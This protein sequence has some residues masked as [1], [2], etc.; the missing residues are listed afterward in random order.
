MTK[1]GR[2]EIRGHVDGYV[3]VST[4]GEEIGITCYC[5]PEIIPQG[6]G[7]KQLPRQNDWRVDIN[8]VHM[9]EGVLVEK[10]EGMLGPNHKDCHSPRLVSASAECST[11]LQQSLK[12]RLQ[13]GMIP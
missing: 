7:T 6:R 12:L 3:K 2:L 13:N 1:M 10:M 4:M 9:S 11:C 5:R 8:H